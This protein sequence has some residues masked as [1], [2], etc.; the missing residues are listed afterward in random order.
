MLPLLWRGTE[1]VLVPAPV[2]R[3]VPALFKALVWPQMV[4]WSVMSRVVQGERP[5]SQ[6]VDRAAASRITNKH[7]IAAGI[8]IERGLARILQCRDKN[9]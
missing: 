5:A 9:K 8:R 7:E 6:I 2:C 3:I 1:T 4:P